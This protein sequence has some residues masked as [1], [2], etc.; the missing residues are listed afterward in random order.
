MNSQPY[1]VKVSASSKPD[2][3]ESANSL[4]KPVPYS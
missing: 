3:K 2:G 1:D 4:T